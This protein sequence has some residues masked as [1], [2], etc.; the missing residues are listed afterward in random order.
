M[1]MFFSLVRLRLSTMVSGSAMVGFLVYPGP[2]LPERGVLLALGI[3]LLA[4]GGSVLNQVQERDL[5]A[6]MARTCLRPLACGTLP[7]QQGLLLALGLLFPA[8]A[9][10][11]IVDPGSGLLGL[12]AL[13]CYNGLYTGLKRRTSFALLPGAL[14]GAMPPLI[15][16]TAAGGELTDYRIV[17]LGGVFF[18]WQMPHFWLLSWKHRDDY[19]R[20]G[21]PLLHDALPER[22]VFRITLFWLS[23]LT[24]ATALLLNLGL[25]QTPTLRVTA[26]LLLTGMLAFGVRA[27]R[28]HRPSPA[29]SG[30]LNLFMAL[31]MAILLLEGLST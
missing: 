16:W 27:V 18:L 31:V 4:A 8:L 10:L 1:E 11:S 23:A 24:A 2:S 28:Y 25:L 26:N 5:D 29:L 6:L 17:L 15:G 19:R 12:C 22:A 21:L 20:A 7:P 3:F 9:L 13:A 30:P 14:C